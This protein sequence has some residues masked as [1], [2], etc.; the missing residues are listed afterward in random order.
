MASGWEEAAAVREGE[1]GLAPVTVAWKVAA[2][3]L[4]VAG[5][6]VAREGVEVRAVGEHSTGMRVQMAMGQ[7]AVLGTWA[8]PGFALQSRSFVPSWHLVAEH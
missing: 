4:A 6:V 3:G 1:V 8:V 5:L 7:L 2:Q